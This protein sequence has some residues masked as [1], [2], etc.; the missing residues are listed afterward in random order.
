[1]NGCNKNGSN[2]AEPRIR[3]SVEYPLVLLARHS[4]GARKKF[5]DFSL[6]SAH[7]VR[8]G[9]QICVSAAIVRFARESVHR[10]LLLSIR[11]SASAA[12]QRANFRMQFGGQQRRTDASEK[13][14][15]QKVRIA[16]NE[17]QQAEGWKRSSLFSSYPE[18]QQLTISPFA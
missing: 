9:M 11:F 10:F 8:R 4:L 14:C 1:M 13:F 3:Q 7:E 2:F 6:L 17:D 15:R 18:P 16:R 5:L 12:Q